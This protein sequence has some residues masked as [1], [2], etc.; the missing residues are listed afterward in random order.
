M[1]VLG[2]G[3]Y[4]DVM[5]GKCDED[6]YYSLLRLF[7]S[8]AYILIALDHAHA[9]EVAIKRMS[10]DL[11]EHLMSTRVY[12]EIRI[13]RHLHH[14][15][16]ISLVDVFSPVLARTNTDSSI[17]RQLGSVFLVFEAL[18]TDLAQILGSGQ[19]LSARHVR[20]MSQQLLRGLAYLHDMGIVH[21]DIKPAN[22]LVNCKDTSVKIADFGLARVIGTEDTLASPPGSILKGHT[23]ASPCGVDHCM[24]LKTEEDGGNSGGLLTGHVVTRW[25]RSPEVILSQQ[26]STAVD[27]WSFGCVFGELLGAL[28][29]AEERK[30][31]SKYSALFQGES[32]GYLSSTDWSDGE[33]SESS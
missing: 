15:H 22:I 3:S 19:R 10:V 24:S 11:G 9:Q 28:H 33:D 21:R 5:L 7:T 14:P 6:I 13:L 27:I 30:S 16:I 17:P 8:S 12:R 31:K 29:P 26:Y 25:Y 1:E 2:N 18:D 4:G 23:L 20:H 32:C